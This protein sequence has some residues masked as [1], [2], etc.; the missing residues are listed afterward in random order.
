M[1]RPSTLPGCAARAPICTARYIGA[2]RK[3]YTSL[4]AG[5]PT[6]AALAFSSGPAQYRRNL[7][8]LACSSA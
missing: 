4:I 8:R 3:S 5:F 7:F 1:G 2:P 6:R